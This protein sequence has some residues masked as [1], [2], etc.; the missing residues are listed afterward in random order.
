MKYKNDITYIDGI[1]FASQK[2]ARHYIYLKSLQ[3]QGSIRNLQLQTVLPF[4][5]NDKTIFRYKP[6]FEYDDASGHHIVDVKGMQTPVFRLKKKLI[7][8]QYQCTIE[9]V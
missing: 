9:I 4:Q 7:E 3:Q 2:E 5:I 6:D 8:A 1:R